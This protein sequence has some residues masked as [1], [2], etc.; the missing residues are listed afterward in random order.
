MY[1]TDRFWFGGGKPGTEYFWQFTARMQLL[2]LILQKAK[3]VNSLNMLHMTQ[4]G[5]QQW[6]YILQEKVDTSVHVSYPK[7]S[8]IICKYMH[9]H[10]RTEKSGY[11]NS[12]RLSNFDPLCINNHTLSPWL[13]VVFIPHLVGSSKNM[14]GGL[15]T[16][17]NAIER[18]FRC[19]PER[20]AVR[21]SLHSAIPSVSMISSTWNNMKIPVFTTI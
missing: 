19:P 14:T 16:S 8:N 9:I 6:Q 7:W 21:V 5:S 11:Q 12:F 15:L 13:Q 10:Q 20:F 17:S 18:R 4:N 3:R 2:V 1:T